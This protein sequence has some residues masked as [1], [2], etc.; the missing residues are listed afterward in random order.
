MVDV[1]PRSQI[2]MYPNSCGLLFNRDLYYRKSSQPTTIFTTKV[3]SDYLLIDPANFTSP[4]DKTTILTV[5]ASDSE[6]TKGVTVSIK[7]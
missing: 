3:Q 1:G 4:A 2:D 7:V 6:T 5:K